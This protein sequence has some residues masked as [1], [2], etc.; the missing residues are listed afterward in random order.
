[1]QGPVGPA[2]AR[3]EAREDE[4]AAAAVLDLLPTLLALG[5]SGYLP[6]PPRGDTAPPGGWWVGRWHGD[7][8]PSVPDAA[9]AA[10]SDTGG[11]GASTDGVLGL[12]P[13][14]QL[15]WR[16]D[17][18]P[19]SEI[20]LVVLGLGAVAFACLAAVLLLAPAPPGMTWEA[21]GARASGVAGAMTLAVFIGILK[22]AQAYLAAARAPVRS[23]R[24]DFGPAERRVRRWR[25]WRTDGGATAPDAIAVYDAVAGAVADGRALLRERLAELG[26]APP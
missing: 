26:I 7:G 17:V 15:V 8:D 19:S 22:L 2:G 3:R 24:T 25:P 14:G 16:P 10:F 18:V 9:P 4:R 23:G 12:R 5:Q 6:P 13:D 11:S 1:M 21:R 20:A